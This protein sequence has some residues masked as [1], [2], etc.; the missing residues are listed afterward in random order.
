M[1]QGIGS[2]HDSPGNS[3]RKRWRAI[4]PLT[5][6][7]CT[8]QH[9]LFIIHAQEEDGSAP[10][11]RQRNDLCSNKVEVNAPSLGTGVEQHDH[12]TRLWIE[13]R[14]I[15][16]LEAI[17]PEAGIGQIVERSLPSVLL[18]DDVIWLMWRQSGLIG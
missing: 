17:A 13:G 6:Q 2:G 9:A 12:L 4:S 18:P 11:R 3:S 16:P 8:Q 10:H 7:L 14:Y 5:E 1:Q 15:R